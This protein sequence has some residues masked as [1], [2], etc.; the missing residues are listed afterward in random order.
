MNSWSSGG[1]QLEVAHLPG[2]DP[3][4]AL[5]RPEVVVVVDDRVVDAALAQ[6]DAALVLAVHHQHAV[7]LRGVEELQQVR[8][9]DLLDLPRHRRGLGGAC[10]ACDRGGLLQLLLA[11]AVVRQLGRRPR[12]AATSLRMEVPM[13]MRS[14]SF[15]RACFTFSPLTKVP[16][17]LPRSSM[18]IL[19]G[20]DGDLRVLARRP[21]PRRAPCPARSSGR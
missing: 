10:A 15:R 5:L 21:C 11:P 16:L 19:P 18:V 6:V 2:D 20:R 14:P 9:R 4:E 8:E 12:P 13:R 7:L 1:L 17:V 3:V